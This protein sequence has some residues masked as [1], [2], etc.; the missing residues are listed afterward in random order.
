MQ[1]NRSKF[2]LTHMIMNG[3]APAADPER[4]QPD[5]AAHDNG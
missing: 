2:P 1:S 3:Q 5:Q 4:N